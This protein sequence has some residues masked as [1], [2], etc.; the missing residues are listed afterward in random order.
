MRNLKK[1]K[2]WNSSST[3]TRNRKRKSKT[4]ANRRR[5]DIENPYGIRERLRQ[6]SR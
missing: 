5:G 3:S 6:S 4:E 2:N 1:I